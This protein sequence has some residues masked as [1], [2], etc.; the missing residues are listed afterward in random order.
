MEFLLNFDHEHK[1][2]LIRMGEVVTEA[3]ALAATAAVRTFAAAEDLRFGIADLSPVERIQ[4]ST[5]FIKSLAT[6]PPAIPAEKTVVLVA[7][8][9]ETYGMSRMF[10]ILRDGLGVRFHVVHT[11]VEAYEMLGIESLNLAAP[12]SS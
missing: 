6:S 5:N 10:Q 7:P 4:V 12:V 1:L 11:M 3:S 9:D 2:L 8:R